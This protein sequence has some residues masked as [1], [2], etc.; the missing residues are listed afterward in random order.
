M[1]IPR[2]ERP[3][4][5]VFEEEYLRPGRPVVL[6]GLLQQWPSW[7]SWSLEWFEGL[8]GDLVLSANNSIPGR[9]DVRVGDF[10][11][12][13]RAGDT[14]GLYLD[15]MPLA[16]LPGMAEAIVRPP[17]CPTDRDTQILVWV[18]P[19]GT[20]LDFHKDN[21]TPLDGNQN[22]LAQLMGSKRI[23]LASPAEDARMYPE[24]QQPNDYL[25]SGVKLDRWKRDEQPL[26]ADVTLHETVVHAGE[27]LFIPAHWWHY[28]RSLET[29]M[30]VTFWW[31][32]SRLI[33]L[34]RQFGEAAR[35][36]AAEPFLSR[37]EATVGAREV[38]ELGGPAAFRS[39]W[40]PLPPRVRA[41]CGRLLQ[42][43]L[44]D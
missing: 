27:V 38:E 35:E 12:A 16:W 25:R 43:D 39:L 11:A 34:L 37:H 17:Y 9:K 18:G 36:G 2:I 4:P 44:R 21:H 1:D 13:L 8:Y 24:P 14:V 23:V 22:L 3:S 42:A 20:C 19:A 29:S 10:L 31:R 5:A 15:A 26:F 40:D 30:T 41:M 32:S 7:G 28:V 6:T 33:E